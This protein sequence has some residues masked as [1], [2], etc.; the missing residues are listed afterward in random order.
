M[1]KGN[2]KVKVISPKL[3]GNEKE[4]DLTLITKY[5]AK[6]NAKTEMVNPG[7]LISRA[8]FPIQ[9]SYGDEMLSIS[10]RERVLVKDKAKIK[11]EELGNYIILR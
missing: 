3:V 8:D 2:K 4:A 11:K 10:P 7:T 9:I 1:G 6:A 5:A